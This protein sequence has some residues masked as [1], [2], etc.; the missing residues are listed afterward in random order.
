MESE[1]RAAFSTSPRQATINCYLLIFLASKWL[2]AIVPVGV[3]VRRPSDP[4]AC[5]NSQ[6]VDPVFDDVAA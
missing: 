1:R 3:T 6:S 4:C 5:Y 2:S